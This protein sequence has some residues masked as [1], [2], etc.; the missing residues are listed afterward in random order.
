MKEA[1]VAERISKLKHLTE[2]DKELILWIEKNYIRL[3][4]KQKLKADE[5]ITYIEN[6]KELV[7]ENKV[8]ATAKKETIPP[9]Q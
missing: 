7:P 1:T 2:K 6:K 8:K 3:T 9:Q 5:A 4:D